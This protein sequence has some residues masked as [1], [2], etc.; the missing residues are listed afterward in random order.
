[1]S[2]SWDEILICTLEKLAKFLHGTKAISGNPNLTETLLSYTQSVN[3]L[4]VFKNF[5][6]PLNSEINKKGVPYVTNQL[7]VWWEMKVEEFTGEEIAKLEAFVA[8]IKKF[9]EDGEKAR[10]AH[11]SSEEPQKKSYSSAIVTTYRSH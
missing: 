8:A 9:L 4:G 11:I 2:K 10:T 6:I 3:S 1:M 7:I 5:F